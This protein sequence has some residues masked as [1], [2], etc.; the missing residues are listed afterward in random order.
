M[1]E[2][3]IRDLFRE[4]RE[5]P[6]PPDSLVRL[7]AGLEGRLRRRG[8]WKAAGWVLAAGALVLATILFRPVAAVPVPA[9]KLIAAGPRE[10]ASSQM[11]APPA[12]RHSIRTRRTIQ[13][14]KH[15]PEPMVIEIETQDPDVVIRLIGD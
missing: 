12:K 8:W 13:P 11:Q 4:M 15:R 9:R 1:T 10:A 2:D 3:D 14:P 6:V 7:R 5:T